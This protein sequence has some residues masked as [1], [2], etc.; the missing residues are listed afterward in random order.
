MRKA[1][2]ARFLI[3]ERSYRGRNRNIAIFNTACG[4]YQ[5]PL[6][7]PVTVAIRGYEGTEDYR[8]EVKSQMP[9]GQDVSSTVYVSVPR[10]GMPEFTQVVR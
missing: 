2:L 1:R 8:F 4:S 5:F 9:G 3:M 10:D 7:I 6:G